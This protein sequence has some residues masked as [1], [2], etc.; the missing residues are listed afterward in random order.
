[1]LKSR[2]E[3]E[4]NE[5]LSES[6]DDA[7]R[8]A[9][10]QLSLHDTDALV[11]YGAGNLGRIVLEKLRGIGVEPS[12]FADD[13]P[14]KQGR[15]LEGLRI[16]TPQ[17]A[18]SEFG[19]RALF[20]VT[21]LNPKA[22]FLEAQCRLHQLTGARV[23]SFLNLAWKYSESFLPYY[24]F[25]LPQAVLAKAA[26]IRRAFHL[27]ADD[28]SRRQ[29]VAH[30]RFRLRLDYEALPESSRGDYFPP[31][32]L[33]YLSPDATF[34]DCGAYDG[35]TLHRFLEHQRGSF[36]QIY[37]FEP[38]GENC[39]KLR[40]YVTG[41]GDE[42]ARK[43][44]IYNAGVGDRRTKLRFNATSNTGASFSSTG[45]VEVDVLPLYE[46]VEQNGGTLYLKFD[47]E[48]AEWEALRGADSLLRSTRPI[49]AISVYHQ[50]D[51]LWQLPLY[52][53]SLNLGYQLFLRTQGEDGMDV[54]CFALPPGYTGT[55]S[56]GS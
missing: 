3:E 52:L 4:L 38:D 19:E 46:V 54:I 18:V 41:L 25:E 7:S 17:D 13:T 33:P 23:I 29:F 6:L 15:T 35:D 39:R 10:T 47:V 45:E 27:F 24:Q 43:V 50:P 55:A 30:I 14:E 44:H 37:A 53:H 31:D 2:A 5:L 20:V 56:E 22:S 26:D 21:I 34:V 16:L 40:E 1:M 51:D 36:S 11:L 28:E 49:L 48:G 8:R 9:A 42:V 32:V 12:A